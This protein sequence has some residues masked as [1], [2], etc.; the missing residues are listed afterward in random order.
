MGKMNEGGDYEPGVVE[1]GG[2]GVFSFKYI[3]HTHTHT[4][5]NTHTPLLCAD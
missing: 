4:H 1:G 2:V 3:L 5:T